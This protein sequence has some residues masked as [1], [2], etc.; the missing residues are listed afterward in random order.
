MDHLAKHAKDLLGI[1]A[2]SVIK[3]ELP[4]V[5]LALAKLKTFCGEHDIDL[6]TKEKKPSEVI[7]PAKW[8]DILIVRNL[9]EPSRMRIGKGPT[10][11]FPPVAVCLED[12]SFSAKESTPSLQLVKVKSNQPI[13]KSPKKAMESP[14]EK[15]STFKVD[16]EVMENFSELDKLIFD[17][18]RE[19]YNK[20]RNASDHNEPQ[21]SKDKDLGYIINL[22]KTYIHMSNATNSTED[23]LAKSPEKDA[24]ESESKGSHKERRFELFNQRYKMS[25]T[26]QSSL[27]KG[28][29]AR[30]AHSASRKKPIQS[31]PGGV[32][33][34]QSYSLNSK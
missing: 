4:S 22:I 26:K 15:E 24:S 18:L 5:E 21:N 25:L 2:A 11:E 14:K 10:E 29:Q 23:T 32:Q 34:D 7:K 1:K 6:S 28:I 30:R 31:I 27:Y 13:G 19:E 20:Q 8:Y 9:E 12:M 17:K 33:S 3:S 16:N